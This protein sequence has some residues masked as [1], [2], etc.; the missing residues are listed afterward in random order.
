MK[1]SYIS[2]GTPPNT[3]GARQRL[4]TPFYRKRNRLRGFTGSRSNG[5]KVS[6]SRFSPGCDSMKMN[7]YICTLGRNLG[8]TWLSRLRR[9]VF[10]S[11][12]F[13]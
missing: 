13:F 11:S 12:F 10:L 2:H 3:E 6:V 1:H 8:T 7:N 4:V 9:T 5:K